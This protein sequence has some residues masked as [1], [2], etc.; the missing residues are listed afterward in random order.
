MVVLYNIMIMD[1][2]AV[3]FHTP[4][5]KTVNVVGEKGSAKLSKN[6]SPCNQV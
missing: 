6:Q 2:S 5:T 3:L 1:E 4:E